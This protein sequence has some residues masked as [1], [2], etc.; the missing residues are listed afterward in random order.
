MDVEEYVRYWGVGNL[1]RWPK[2]RLLESNL[3]EHS[4]SFLEFAGLPKAP[5]A[6]IRA[7]S[8]DKQMPA[9]V[10]AWIVALEE[11]V[12]ICIAE[13]GQVVAVEGNLRAHRFVNAS[14]EKFAECVTLFHRYQSMVKGLD[15]DM[16][17]E[18]V[19]STATALRSSDP[20]AFGDPQNYWP[21]I[22]EQM[23]EGS[24]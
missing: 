24:L 4:R 11:N 15:E 1:V 3:D 12:P 9:L 23:Q 22:V 6:T 21:I 8:A 19:A 2:E 17:L 5:S 14:V 20:V 18:L 13:S 10:G 16:A 7:F